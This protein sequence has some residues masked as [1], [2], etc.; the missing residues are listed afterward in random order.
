MGIGDT[1]KKIILQYLDKI[2]SF[3]ELSKLKIGIGLRTVE[4]LKRYF[5]INNTLKS[6]TNIVNDNVDD[7]FN[8]PNEGDPPNKHILGIGFLGFGC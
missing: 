2:N 5:H 3:D 1:K 4:K 7:V 6:I 8:L